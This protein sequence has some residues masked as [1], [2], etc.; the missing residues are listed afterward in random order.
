MSCLIERKVVNP[1][2]K[3][4]HPENHFV[5]FGDR[6]DYYIPVDC[7]VCV[8]CVNKYKSSWYFR[9]VKEFEYYTIEQLKRSYYVTLTMDPLYYSESKHET[10][11]LFR[12]FLERVRKKTGHSVRH[13]FISER[14]DAEDGE[15][16]IHFHGFLFDISFNPNLIWSFWNYG[17]VKVKPCINPEVPLIEFIGYCAGYI[18]KEVDECII[19]KFDKPYVFVSPGLGKS[20]AT[21][22]QNIA[23]HH[24]NNQLIP[25]VL[26]NN[27]MRSLP[28]YLRQKVFSDDALKQMKNDYFKNIS[29]DILPPAPYYIGK[30]QFEDYTVY[31]R[32]IKEIKNQYIEKYGNKSCK[33][34]YGLAESES[35]TCQ[36]G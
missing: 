16:R 24:Q 32:A 5:L 22:P 30:Q 6:D 28:R 15:H 18:T 33:K 10:R 2:Y 12:R 13:F 3:K 1:R 11:L 25:F 17:F 34:I 26:E 31:Q 27:T 19:D 9:L 23:F 29:D 4:I 20:Y 35:P 8:N 7:G 14:G 36:L 21:D